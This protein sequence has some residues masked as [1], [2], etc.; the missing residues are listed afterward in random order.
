MNSLDNWQ[1]CVDLCCT[2]ALACGC[3]KMLAPFTDRM[4]VTLS[5]IGNYKQIAHFRSLFH[6]SIVYEQTHS[7]APT[8]WS[9]NMEIMKMG[10]AW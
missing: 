5:E 10:L 7:Q 8:F 6:S 1:L 2:R 4:T 9:I 3:Y